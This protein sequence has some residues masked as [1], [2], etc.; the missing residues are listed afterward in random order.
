MDRPCARCH[1][2]RVLAGVAGSQLQCRHHR[3]PGGPTVGSGSDVT[4]EVAGLALGAE[5][6]QLQRGQQRLDIVTAKG[7][8][9]ELR[10]YRGNLCLGPS[11]YHPP[12]THRSPKGKAL[13][14][15]P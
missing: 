11:G 12:I 1:A 2:C 5:R 8:H 10:F 15:K 3:W 4:A 7:A 13:K 6:H 9:I 14:V